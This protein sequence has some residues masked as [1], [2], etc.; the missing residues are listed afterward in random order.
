MFS[1][2]LNF[3]LTIVP[4]IP[5]LVTSIENLFKGTPKSGP[6]KWIAV[7]Q[8]LSQSIS[9]VSGEIAKIAPAGTTAETIST[10]LV[11]FSKDVNDAFVKLA[12]DLQ[13]FT[14]SGQP[15]VNS[16]PAAPA[17]KK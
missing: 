13:L 10:A 3:V 9:T 8:A 6:Q 4:V 2:I 17:A 12:N 1:T 16:L 7:E 11:V 5:Q 14:H 15:A